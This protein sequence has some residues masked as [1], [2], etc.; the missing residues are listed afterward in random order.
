MSD[1]LIQTMAGVMQAEDGPGSVTVVRTEGSTLLDLD[2]SDHT[3]AK[4]RVYLDYHM[5]AA[6][7]IALGSCAAEM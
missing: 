3:G 6:L 4:V 5:V 2:V 7:M 1:K